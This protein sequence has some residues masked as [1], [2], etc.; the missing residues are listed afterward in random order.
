[1]KIL[2]RA[3]TKMGLSH[4]LNFWEADVGDV[5]L[6]IVYKV[7]KKVFISLPP[8]FGSLGWHWQKWGECGIVG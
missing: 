5:I 4:M 8:V 6:L 7:S 1:V 2:A 3:M